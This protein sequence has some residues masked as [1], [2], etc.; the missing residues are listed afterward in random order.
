MRTVNIIFS[1]SNM[2]ALCFLY[3]K[4]INI[5]IRK[6]IVGTPQGAEAHVNVSVQECVPLATLYTAHPVTRALDI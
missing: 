4:L 2:V 6:G 5:I 3:R 1:K